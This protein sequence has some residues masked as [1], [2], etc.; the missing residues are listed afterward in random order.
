MLCFKQRMIKKLQ[1]FLWFICFSTLFWSVNCSRPK[2]I[3]IVGSYKISEKDVQYRNQVF[4]NY[5]PEDKRELGKEELVRA[6]TLAQILKNNAQPLDDAILEK[7]AKRIDEKSQMPGRLQ[8]LKAI[9]GSDRDAYLRCFVLPVYVERTLYYEFFLKNAAIQKESLKEA[10]DFL[11]KA[12]TSKNAF[13][14]LKKLERF[15][16]SRDAKLQTQGFVVDNE[17]WLQGVVPQ[18]K[19][20][21][22]FPKIIDYGE[23]WMVAKLQSTTPKNKTPVYH[24]E[25]ALFPKRDYSSWLEAEKQKVPVEHLLK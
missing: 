4:K 22:V 24:F 8:Q 19:V 18:V 10:E 13:A 25:A 2:V 11:H 20:G 9:F 12:V 7:E 15:S 21:Q 1:T 5:F 16:V 23:H 6:F 3:A 17:R 14:V